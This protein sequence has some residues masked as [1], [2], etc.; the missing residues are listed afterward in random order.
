[1]D[2][3]EVASKRSAP[4]ILVFDHREKL[5]FSNPVALNILMGPGI[6]EHP[7]SR[8]AVDRLI[9]KPIYNLY[10]SLRNVSRPHQNNLGSILSRRSV[11]FFSQEITY[12]C[13]GS[14]LRRSADSTDKIFHIMI[15]IE[16]ISQNRVADLDTFRKHFDLTD[17]QMEIVKR[18]LIGWSNKEIAYKLV[19][20]E[21]TV[22]GHLR[23]IT[24][25]LG[26]NSRTEIF[27]KIFNP[28]NK[29]FPSNG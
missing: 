2:F 4:G 17:R 19:L 3:L 12:C 7:A 21:D 27:A 6:N 5:I 14:F 8:N 22:K 9:P 11:L 10:R 13:R 1:M 28:D 23:N 16:K 20:S 29:P 26:V 24:K 15:M 18:L 25:R